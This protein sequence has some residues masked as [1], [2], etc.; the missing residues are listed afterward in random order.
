MQYIFELQPAYFDLVSGVIV[1]TDY[2]K[3]APSFSIYGAI[4]KTD[5]NSAPTGH[6]FRLHK[7]NS[8]KSYCTVN[9]YPTTCR[10]MVNG[11]CVT[12][13]ITINLPQINWLVRDGVERMG[14]SLTELNSIYRSA[15]S[16][17]KSDPHA[18]TNRR[19]QAWQAIAVNDGPR[20]DP[21]AEQAPL[22]Q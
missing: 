14:Y 11:S 4:S 18:Q 16:S 2:I 20:D 9:L 22:P 13:F 5:L 15:L 21:L 17:N 19:S 7:P 10:I 6:T 12:D 3:N 1:N 8:K